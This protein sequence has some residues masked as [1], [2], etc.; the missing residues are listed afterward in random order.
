MPLSDVPTIDVFAY[1]SNLHLHRMQG[2][3]PSARPV[4]IGYVVGRK[5]DFRKRSLDGSAK[6]D[7]KLTGNHSD[8]LWG[9]IYSVRSRDKRS[10]DKHE[11]LGIGY[12]EVLVE[13]TTSVAS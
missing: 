1:G 5:I 3:A 2:R 12:D 7:A 8:R 10:L 11:F 13:V 6:A 9:V 4:E